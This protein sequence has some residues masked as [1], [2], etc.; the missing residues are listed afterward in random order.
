MLRSKGLTSKIIL[1][2]VDGMDPRF[3]R[4]LVDE[5]KLPNV[6]KYMELGACREDLQ[7]LGGVPTI[8]PPMWTTL[9]TGAYPN[10]H[11]IYDFNL[12]VPGELDLNVSAVYSK[13]CK[14]EQIW[15]VTAEAGKQTYVWHWPGSAWPPSSKSPNLHVIDS[16][17]PGALGM[18]Y[19]T[20]DSDQIAVAST[21]T[22]KAGF[23]RGG[24]ADSVNV[25]L[26]VED[27][28]PPKPPYTKTSKKPYF[29]EVLA[30]HF[31][32]LD[33][34]GYQASP[35]DMRSD[36]LIDS[37]QM[38]TLTEFPLGLSLS[39]ITEAEGWAAAPA[40]AKEFVI[41]FYYG[42]VQRPALILKNDKGEYNR[43]AIYGSK[44]DKEPQKVLERDTFTTLIYDTVERPDK[45]FHIY[46]NARALE[47]APDGSMVKIW[48]SAGIDYEN[49]TVWYPKS[50]FPKIMKKFGPPIP[51]CM[52][53]GQDPNLIS[54]CSHEQWKVAAKWQADCLKYL[55]DEEGAE[56][57]FSHY[58][59]PD[60]E[61]HSY[62]K[63][64]K[65]RDFSR[66]DE[67]DVLKMAEETYKL[68]DEYL[69]Q[70]L[71]YID[72][73]WTVLIFSDHALVCPQ[74][75]PHHI[76]DNYG[77]NAG[78]MKKLGYT[79]L[80]KD[81]QGKELPEIDWKKTTA[82]QVCSNSIFINLKGRD[83]HGIIDPKDKYELEEK[84]ITDLYNYKD[85]K[86]GHRVV[87]LALHNKDAILLGLGGPGGADIVF[88][89]HEDYNYDHGEAL[90]TA[91]GYANTSTSPIF[92]AAGPGIKKGFRTERRIREVDVTPTVAVL[93]GVRMPENAEG[94]PA[95]Q[96]LSEGM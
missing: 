81:A 20:I 30:K 67:K 68:T 94:A 54:K 75:R 39:P 89:V 51:T 96:I 78:V 50:L 90:S 18:Q 57:I 47:I 62:M 21:K 52:A 82:L 65:N 25:P 22:K 33:V 8:T 88:F 16:T 3:T 61:G 87:S 13:Y 58:H 72:K 84:I 42:M 74:E 11:G 24:T 40:G 86:T 9:A 32:G 79:V 15:N 49:D 59:G 80:Q 38:D 14:A 10:T 60:L 36:L 64:L 56:V 92:M 1:L 2:G 5:G 71:P 41:F 27:A 91:E 43:V 17:S 83:R 37:S 70:F 34:N 48:F 46:R 7:L 29:D 95:Y 28:N 45:T 31:E 4:K 6:K 93:L 53:S 66:I 77:V 19:A 55:M 76:G 44:A 63:H 12:P 73:G 26:N 23:V 69:G 85:E 35:Y